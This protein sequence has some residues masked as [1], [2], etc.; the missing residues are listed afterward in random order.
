VEFGLLGPLVVRRG[1]QVIPISFG[2]QRVLLAALLAR[3]N[4]VVD[5][6]DVAELIWGARPPRSA[7]VTLQNYVKRLRQALGSGDGPARIRTHPGGYL[8]D[9]DPAEL[10]LT[11]F[12][13]L[14]RSGLESARQQNWENAA[15][16]L[17]TALALWRGEPFSDISCEALALRENPWL[18]ELRLQAL[19]ARIDADLHLGRPYQVIAE[20]QQLITAEP[21]RERLHSLLM[22][23]LYQCGQQAAAL[24]AYR[25]A[26]HAL[27]E[28]AGIDPGH[29]LQQ[30]HQRILHCDP[31]LMLAQQLGP[32][33]PSGHPPSAT[34]LP[35]YPARATP[36][37]RPTR[38]GTA[39][40]GRPPASA[41]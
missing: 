41:R 18:R 14:C 1:D 29:E 25:Q 6:D 27:T 38:P 35:G 30:L 11:R 10:D 24:E 39:H 31:G 9:A 33:A 17:T 20:L 26:R 34:R 23:A 8:I 36:P 19:E 32:A 13:Q 4:Q 3:A 2:N 37:R 21:L 28:G 40:P 16:Q 22:L 7:R 12:R 15:G 5:I